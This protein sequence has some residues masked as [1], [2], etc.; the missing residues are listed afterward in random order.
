MKKRRLAEDRM[1]G[2]PC[3][4]R[5]AGDVRDAS[6]ARERAEASGGGHC[7]DGMKSPVESVGDVRV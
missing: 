6:G 3:T 5:G 1:S 4:G 7:G 2:R